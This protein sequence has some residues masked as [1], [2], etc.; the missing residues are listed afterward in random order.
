MQEKKNLVNKYAP[1]LAVSLSTKERDWPMS[2][3]C[4]GISF[5]Y[6]FVYVVVVPPQG[7]VAERSA[8]DEA[9][10]GGQQ[11]PAFG[12][13]GLGRQGL[14]RAQLQPMTGKKTKKKQFALSTK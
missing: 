10:G 14:P 1:S 7:E 3:T 4:V 11:L 6:S 8:Q 13:R 5:I 9:D 2:E 12:V